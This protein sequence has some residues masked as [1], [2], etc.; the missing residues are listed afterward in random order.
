MK[1]N[2]IIKSAFIL[3]GTYI[4]LLGIVHS[5][6]FQQIHHQYFIK[7]NNVFFAAY[8]NGGQVKFYEVPKAYEKRYLTYD[9]LIKLSSEQQRKRAIDKAR[10]AGKAK[11]TYEPVQ[12]DINTWATYGMLY[13]FLLAFVIA[14]PLK[15]KNKLFTLIV[16]FIL[17]E[18]F[19]MLKIWVLLTLKFS[20]WQ[21]KFEVG[22]TN[23]FLIDLLNYFLIIITFPFF[24]MLF[25][26]I[27][28]LLVS[29]RKLPK[30]INA[31]QFQ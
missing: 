30:L 17:T 8:G 3:L 28:N 9:V 26:V 22:W 20:L 11:V 18:A 27:V 19:F 21:K 10:K 24:G 23:E 5:I 31:E 25:I 1:T 15:W 16:S 4:L 13:I 7:K 6:N 29:G 12:Y 2:W 14:L